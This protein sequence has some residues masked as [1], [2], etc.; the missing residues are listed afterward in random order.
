MAESV[1]KSSSSNAIVHKNDP[2]QSLLS[3]F[4]DLS[5]SFSLSFLSSTRASMGEFS[6]GSRGLSM[7]V[8]RQL[9][10]SSTSRKC[11]KPKMV[12]CDYQ[13]VPRK[14]SL[15]SSTFSTIDKYS[16]AAY[17]DTLRFR[18]DAGVSSPAVT[19]SEKLLLHPTLIT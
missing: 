17:G 12:L 6:K 4:V 16:V 14:V 3:V 1:V 2:E 11:V 7:Q 5:L 10:G 19:W 18:L 15:G 8:M 13:N 9:W